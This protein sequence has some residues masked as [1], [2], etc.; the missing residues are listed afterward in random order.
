MILGDVSLY[1]ISRS[2]YRQSF[3]TET[4]PMNVYWEDSVREVERF[5]VRARKPG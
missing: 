4:L 1:K 2:A 5:E 3:L